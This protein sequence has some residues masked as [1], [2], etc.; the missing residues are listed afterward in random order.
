LFF[1]HNNLGT[2]LFATAE[3]CLRKN[4]GYDAHHSSCTCSDQAGQNDSPVFPQRTATR[5]PRPTS[6]IPHRENI[7]LGGV[8][9]AAEIGSIAFAVKMIGTLSPSLKNNASTSPWPSYLQ[10]V[11]AFFNDKDNPHLWESSVQ[12][13]RA[14]ISRTENA[15]RRLELRK[16]VTPSRVGDCGCILGGTA[17]LARESHEPHCLSHCLPTEESEMVPLRKGN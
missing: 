11:Q 1:D 14:Q 6:P 3:I 13:L 8:A 15:R 2:H 7:H 9:N 12:K 10:F 17:G 5:Q 16:S 4:T